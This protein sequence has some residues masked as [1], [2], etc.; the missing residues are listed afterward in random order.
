MKQRYGLR[1]SVLLGL[2][3]AVMAS[4]SWAQQEE[5]GEAPETGP[6]TPSFVYVNPNGTPTDPYD[7]PQTG[8]KSIQAAINAVEGGEIRVMPGTYSETEG[9]KINEASPMYT[10]TKP[11]HLIGMGATRDEVILDAKQKCQVLHLECP[12]AIV[13]NLTLANGKYDTNVGTFLFLGGNLTQ[14]DGTVKNCVISNG[15]GLMCGSAYV[16][17]GHI[18]DCDFTKGT[19]VPAGP[20]RPAGGLNIYGPALVERCRFYDNAGAYGAGVYLKDKDAIV[21]DCEIFNNKSSRW[22]GG[23]ALAGGLVERCVI[24]NNVSSFGGGGVF[25]GQRWDSD[26]VLSVVQN[27]LI[28]HNQAQGGVCGPYNWNNGGGGGGVSLALAEGVVRHCTIV[29]NTAL[30]P[31]GNDVYISAGAIQ[32]SIIAPANAEKKNVSVCKA[33]GTISHSRVP[34]DGLG[35][36]TI[37]DDPIF[38]NPGDGNFQLCYG[39][40]CVDAGEEIADVTDDLLGRS[41]PVGGYDLG[42]YEMDFSDSS[43]LFAIFHADQTKGIGELVVTFE[44][45]MENAAEG[46][47]SYQWDFGDGE[48]LN[49]DEPTAEH[50]FGPGLYTVTLTVSDSS[51]KTVKVV[52]NSYIQVNP[53]LFDTYVSKDGLNEFP[54]DTEVK[55]AH[56]LKDAIDTVFGTDDH[57][58][59]VHIAPGTYSDGGLGTGVRSPMYHIE[60]PVRLVGEGT[61]RDDVVLDAAQTCQVL[62]LDHP[63]ASAEN[64]TMANGKCEPASQVP[65]AGNLTLLKG[66]AKNCVISNGYGFNY[67]NA[68]VKDGAIIDSEFCKG[69]VSISGRDR[70]AGGVTIEGAGLVENCRIHDNLGSYGAGLSLWGKDAVA[71]DCVIYNNTVEGYWSNGGGGVSMQGGLLER[72]IITNNTTF[73][74]GGGIIIEDTNNKSPTIVRSCLIAD[75]KSTATTLGF[76]QNGGGGGI[77]MESAH[78][79][80]INCTLINN[81]VTELDCANDILLFNGTIVN[82]IVCSPAGVAPAKSI[83]KTGGEIDY[84]LVPALDIGGEHNFTAADPDFRDPENGDYSLHATSPCI[85]KGNNAYWEGVEN[86]VD[87]AGKDRIRHRTVD[88][89]AYEFTASIGTMLM[90]R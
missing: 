68:Y 50:T 76:G 13:E 12:D 33:G 25:L 85:N 56:S 48:T 57:P 8:F 63:K 22:G 17:N 51:Q 83:E 10:I 5:G 21:R 1:W 61:S 45:T 38:A 75:N 52:R 16:E 26:K 82:T 29:G 65:T 66:L 23:V 54:Y 81:S 73:R 40:P 60:R 24:T 86:P 78:A 7:T 88:V 35:D 32:N 39:S 46:P 11:V 90:V 9:K 71:R 28:A 6:E 55:A 27:C 59:V 43:K 87:L 34:I 89:G 19:V 3:A 53:P 41:R 62:I 74:A 67:G 20:D 64:L 30:A 18:F 72:C 31:S 14:L 37:F 84:C 4:P 49:V 70:P 79:T 69:S 36:T 44:V 2:S 58:G 80:I 15:Y 77:A 42:C 47:V